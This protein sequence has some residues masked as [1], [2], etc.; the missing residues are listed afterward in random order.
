[1]LYM[2][3]NNEFYMCGIMGRHGTKSVFTIF[4]CEQRPVE[5]CEFL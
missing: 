1:M 2:Y 5:T 4:W 3:S